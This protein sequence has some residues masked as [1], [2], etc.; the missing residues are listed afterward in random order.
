MGAI[1]KALQAVA[2]LILA[3]AAAV[4]ISRWGL[5][6]ENDLLLQFGSVRIG[7][8]GIGAGLSLVTVLAFADGWIRVQRPKGNTGAGRLWNGIGFGLLPGIAVWKCFEQASS[9]STGTEI[10]KGFFQMAWLTKDGR[11]LPARTEMLL[12][13]IL[14]GTIAVWLIARREDFPDNGDLAGISVALWSAGR[15]VTDGFHVNQPGLFGTGGIMGWLAAGLMLII[16]IHWG[17]RA[18]RKRKHTG[19]FPVCISVFLL[20]VALIVLIRNRILSFDHPA[21]ELVLICCGALLA[22]KAVLCMGRVSR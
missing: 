16:L 21:A 20:S 15:L 22:L 14:F 6:E 12:A 5:P 19:F 17:G 8:S 4:V 13:V 11:F 18:F 2:G 3:A 1:R 9:Q 10:P 7:V